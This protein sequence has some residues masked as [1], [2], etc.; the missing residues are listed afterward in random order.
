MQ[1]RTLLSIIGAGTSSITGCMAWSDRVD[2]NDGTTENTDLPD[3]CPTSQELGIE[4]PHHLD[5]ARAESFVE[6]YESVYYREIVVAY[7]PKSH[8]DAYE[9]GGS[10]TDSPTPVGDG[11]ELTY[12]G[13]GGIYRP[14]LLLGATT[15]EPPPGADLVSV[16]EI[17]D[18]PLTEVLEEAA[19]TGDS[20]FHVDT[21]GEEVD[22]YVDRFASLSDDFNR[23][24][25]PGD[26]DSLYVNVSGTPVELSVQATNLHGDYGWEARYYVDVHVVRRTTD[27]ATAPQSGDLLECRQLG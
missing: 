10:V 8:L 19:E 16:S 13:G 27:D 7:E 23:L 25:G 3:D 6:A 4:W 20:E 18:Q 15:A 14:T 5:M 24:S 9:L 2:S 17:D 12:M 22:R 1:R 26:S 21:P 11:W